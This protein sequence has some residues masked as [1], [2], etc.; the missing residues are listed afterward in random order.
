MASGKER[1]ISEDRAEILRKTAKKV[2]KSVDRRV[3]GYLEG[4][5]DPKAEA[6]KLTV[7]GV[8]TSLVVLS[9]LT[10]K[11]RE[12]RLKI[13][14]IHAEFII[15]SEKLQ[16]HLEH[17]R[18]GI[19]PPYQNGICSAELS[20]ALI[21]LGKGL[22]FLEIAV[23][24]PGYFPYMIMKSGIYGRR[25][26]SR[27]RS[28]ADKVAVLINIPAGTDLNDLAC[29]RCAIEIICLAGYRLV[30]FEIKYYELA[31]VNN[32]LA[33]HFHQAVPQGLLL[34]N[35]SPSYYFYKYTYISAVLR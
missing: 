24:L 34:R 21:C 10:G 25:Y 8:T 11:E 28:L 4:T 15:H 33:Q 29:K 16:I 19:A 2:K 1:S 23:L 9:L 22:A 3:D 12:D 20:E 35:L 18:V 14:K 32:F 7:R 13:E 26:I 6:R 27:E 17:C 31:T 5:Y 30:P